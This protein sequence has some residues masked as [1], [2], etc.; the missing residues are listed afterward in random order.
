LQKDS[1]GQRY[2]G[3]GGVSDPKGLFTKYNESVLI[4]VYLFYLFSHMEESL[5]N[6]I[7][8]PVS[9]EMP[10]TKK[11][12]KVGVY[13]LIILLAFSLLG[14]TY[15]VLK[16]NG[17]NL[18]EDVIGDRDN[19][20]ENV[21]GDNN[22]ED[23]DPEE[24]TVCTNEARLD[25]GGW[26]LFSL[27]QYGFGVEI[28]TYKM[29]SM[30]GIDSAQNIYSY[31]DVKHADYAPDAFD[32]SWYGKVH[33]D[34]EHHVRIEFFPSRIPD[35]FGCGQ[36]CVKEH[37]F[38]IYIF[39]NDGNENYEQVKKKYIDIFSVFYPADN[40]YGTESHKD[41]IKWGKNVLEYTIVGI[42]GSSKGYIVIMDKY[43]FNILYYID[44]SVV[45]SQ[46]I[47]QRVLDSMKFE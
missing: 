47:A 20:Q 28:P 16:D 1:T 46:Q 21:T 9:E 31:W 33:S 12:Q 25:N 24:C 35:N 15:F 23:S 6:D 13:A 39:E 8:V 32:I 2:L 29:L 10:E 19:K 36:G 44:S 14:L 37:V 34:L 42:G 41:S 11:P 17:I 18:L 7:V 26:G 27:P 40:E 30:P 3:D 22:V 43:I 38:D 5:Q 45:E 4:Y